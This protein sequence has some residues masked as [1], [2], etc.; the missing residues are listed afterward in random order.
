[1]KRRLYIAYG[2]NIN[3]V[4]MSF[5]CPKATVVGKG[6]IL[7]HELLF[8]GTKRGAYATVEP[9]EGAKVPV[10][11]WSITEEDEIALD[12]YEG[13]PH[14]YEKKNLLVKTE[15]GTEEIMA[16][17]M[18]NGHV[19]GLPSAFYLDTIEQGYASVGFDEEYLHER[20]DHCKSL[21]KHEKPEEAV[22]MKQRF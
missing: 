18:T 6:E 2:S 1:M 7:D 3:L 22:W 12:R 21:L 5:R 17:V 8:K 10:L 13:Y 15:K 11:I 16:Y 20:V 9:K 4:Q 14:F 19:I